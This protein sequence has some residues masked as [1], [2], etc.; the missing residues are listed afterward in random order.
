MLAKYPVGVLEFSKRVLPDLY[1]NN[2]T[3]V[4]GCYEFSAE[5]VHPLILR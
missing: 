5:F 4:F 1:N 2:L 3:N